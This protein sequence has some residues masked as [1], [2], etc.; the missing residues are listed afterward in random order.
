MTAR[1]A[2]KIAIKVWQNVEPIFKQL[3]T[4]L[5][6]KYRWHGRK[7]IT[8]LSCQTNNTLLFVLWKRLAPHVYFLKVDDASLKII[9]E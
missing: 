7:S 2:D 9:M 4:G 8:C 3:Y 5:C 1:Y 6:R